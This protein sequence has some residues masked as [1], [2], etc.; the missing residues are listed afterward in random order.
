[1]ERYKQSEEGYRKHERVFTFIRKEGGRTILKDRR[2]DE[3][4]KIRM[5]DSGTVAEI[6]ILIHGRETVDLVCAFETSRPVSSD[7]LS[8]TSTHILMLL[9]LPKCST[10][11]KINI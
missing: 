4:I 10:V 1:M 8:L 11:W 2:E 3:Y 5:F 6:Y 9:I 7:T